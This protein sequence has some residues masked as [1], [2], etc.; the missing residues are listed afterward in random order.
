MQVK[1]N[2]FFQSFLHTLTLP[3]VNTLTDN[4]IDLYH[5]KC[6]MC[7]LI[8]RGLMLLSQTGDGGVEV[9]GAKVLLSSAG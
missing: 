4:V 7:R 3:S 9:W 1:W 2:L 8:P 5:V 6:R